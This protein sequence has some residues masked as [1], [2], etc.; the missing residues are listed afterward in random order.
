MCITGLRIQEAAYLRESNIDLEAHRVCLEKNV[1]RTKGGKP[2]ITEAFDKES[3]AYMREMKE[4]GQQCKTGHLF[5]DRAGL[6][7]HVRAEIR[8]ACRTLGITCLG[9]H[10]FRKYNAQK[11]YD[12]LC[13]E[14]LDDETARRRVSRHLGHNRIRDTKVSYVPLQERQ[15]K[16]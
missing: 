4:M 16:M 8:R 13:N 14:G 10:A 2:R 7:N 3:L 11:L 6:P 5:A 12:A 9:S 1:N 15:L